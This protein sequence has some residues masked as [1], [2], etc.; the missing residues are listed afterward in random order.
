M[1]IRLYVVCFTRTYPLRPSRAI[2][3]FSVRT[4]IPVSSLMIL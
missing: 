3:R 2:Q 4:A 1:I